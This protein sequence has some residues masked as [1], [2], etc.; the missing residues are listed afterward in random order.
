AVP[1]FFVGFEKDVALHREWFNVV[2][3]GVPSEWTSNGNISLSAQVIRFF[4]TSTAFEYKG[5]SFH[6]TLV[7]LAPRT[8]TVLRFGIS[9]AVLSMMGFLALRFHNAPEL[10]SKWGI[11]ALAFA[12]VPCFSTIAEVP[13]LVVLGP[14]AI[15]LAH[16][17][18]VEG[19]N[20]WPLQWLFAGS[21]VLTTFT[22]KTFVG[23]FL[24]K[25]FAST[26]VVMFGVVLLAAA[27]VRSLYLLE[28]RSDN[29]EAIAQT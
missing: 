1:A 4:T 21:F 13:H 16:V 7:E 29:G 20:E 26:G 27:V 23:E 2:L 11:Y 28:K 3:L 10:I 6:L 9:A 19:V 14:A 15:F 18:F 12:L 5:V 8:V 24:G 22:S 25:L 17:I